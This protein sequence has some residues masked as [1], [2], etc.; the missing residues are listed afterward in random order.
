VIPPDN[1]YLLFYFFIRPSPR[2]LSPTQAI[3]FAFPT[4][5]PTASEG[6]R[7]NCRQFLAFPILSVLVLAQEFGHAQRRQ[8][9][10]SRLSTLCM[11]GGT[12]NFGWW[13][14]GGG[15]RSV[16]TRGSFNNLSSCPNGIWWQGQGFI[17][18]CDIPVFLVI[19]AWLLFSDLFVRC[20]SWRFP[21][22]LSFGWYLGLGRT[23]MTVSSTG[24]YT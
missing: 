21:R 18:V 6:R 19:F 9:L 17:F 20:L 13:A 12:I 8:A 23:V 7:S 1:R 5:A 3:T 10:C 14:D 16:F 15:R 24:I 2:N 4:R 11:A 22:A